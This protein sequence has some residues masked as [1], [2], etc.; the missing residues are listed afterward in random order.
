MFKIVFKLHRARMQS[1]LTQKEL[2]KL[3]GFSQSYIS[4]LELE[5][6]SPTLKVIERLANVLKIHPDEMVEIEE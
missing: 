2:A 3:C 6:K 4:D 1:H 5:T